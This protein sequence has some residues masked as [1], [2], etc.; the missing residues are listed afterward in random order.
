MK[1]MIWKLTEIMR[2]RFECREYMDAIFRNLATRKHYKVIKID[3]IEA[4]KIP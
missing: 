1:K 2:E 3:I 4:K